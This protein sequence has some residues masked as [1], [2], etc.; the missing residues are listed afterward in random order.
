MQPDVVYLCRAGDNEEIRYSLRSLANL[1]HGRVW[2]FGDAPLWYRGRLVQTDQSGSKYENAGGALETACRCADVSSRFVLMNDDFYL[3]RPVDAVPVAHRGTLREVHDF[4]AREHP[5]SRYT[6]HLAA[7]LDLLESLGH[8]EPLCY[9]LHMPMV[10][11]RDRAAALLERY[12]FTSYLFRSVYGNL[13]ELGGER[14]EDCKVYG[15]AD[16]VPQGAFASSVDGAF[17][18]M[19]PVLRYLF[20]DPCELEREIPA[21][22][23]TFTLARDVTFEGRD[24][25]AG[26]L[27]PGG[28]AVLM[29]G[30]GVLSD[31]RV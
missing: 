20:P 6:A 30:A 12:D 7:T 1:P 22:P 18:G 4:Y 9:E 21:D 16:P 31:A 3:M 24:F 23:R 14:L 8:P 10:V 28:L 13:L 27:I 29:K 26:A 5:A 15:K 19:L 11:E 17:A 25:A 2:L